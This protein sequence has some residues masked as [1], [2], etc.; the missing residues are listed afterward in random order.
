MAQT[1]YLLILGA[2]A[3][4]YNKTNN[5]SYGGIDVTPDSNWKLWGHGCRSLS[6]FN[7]PT[8]SVISTSVFLQPEY[9]ATFPHAWILFPVRDI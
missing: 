7:L 6:R 8:V 5:R 1:P 4:F 9:E 2:P 3:Y